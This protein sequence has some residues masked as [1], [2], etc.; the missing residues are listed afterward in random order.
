M[1]SQLKYVD[2][3]AYGIFGIYATLVYATPIIGGYLADR[4]IGFQRAI[5][6]G[7]I[8]I[9]C[10]HLCM[11]MSFGEYSLYLGLGLIV[12]GTGFFKSNISAMVGL[13]YESKDQKRDAGFTLFYLGI[14]IGG[15][16]APLVCGYIGMKF[17][18]HYGFGIASFGMLLGVLLLVTQKHHFAN[19]GLP[20]TSQR[21]TFKWVIVA[22]FLAAPIFAWMIYASDLFK[23]IL[24]FVG[25]AFLIYMFKE[26]VKCTPKERR[27]LLVLTLAILLLLLSGVLIEQ[28]STSLMLFVERNVDRVVW[29]WTIPAAF[30]QSIDPMTVLIFGGVVSQLW[31]VLARRGKDLQPATKY[32]IAFTII[33]VSYLV[34]YLGSRIVDENALTPLTFAFGSMVLLSLGDIFIYPYSIFMLKTVTTKTPRRNDGCRLFSVS[35]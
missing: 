4:V 21:A 8:I 14:N 18:W 11:A 7:G 17:G 26:G 33:A 27:N 23:N 29:G 3:R 34:L 20:P 13:L 30:F 9:A 1:V 25:I 19:L 6:L 10:G 24:P 31:L 32:L 35:E 16:L 12:S 22:G 5:I 15:F 2:A 28:S